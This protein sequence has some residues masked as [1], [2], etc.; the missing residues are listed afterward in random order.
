MTTVSESKHGPHT[1]MGVLKGL[2]VRECVEGS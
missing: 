2:F 1:H